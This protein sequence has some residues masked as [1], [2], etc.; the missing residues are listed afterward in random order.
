MS[1]NQHEKYEGGSVYLSS[2]EAS[3]KSGKKYKNYW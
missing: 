3:L 1:N 2:K